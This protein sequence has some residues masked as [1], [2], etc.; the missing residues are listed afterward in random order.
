MHFTTSNISP[1]QILQS[2]QF[3]NG[4]NLSRGAGGGLQS[5]RR[6]ESGPSKRGSGIRTQV[7]NVLGLSFL[8]YLLIGSLRSLESIYVVSWE[9]KKMGRTYFIH[10]DILAYHYYL[11]VKSFNPIPVLFLRG[12]PTRFSYHKKLIWLFLAIFANTLPTLPKKL[13]NCT[14]L[15]VLVTVSSVSFWNFC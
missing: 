4:F 12:L 15:T 2:T 13:V 6:E 7:S 3:G 8:N 14:V 9:K 10:I 1:T 5:A 11:P